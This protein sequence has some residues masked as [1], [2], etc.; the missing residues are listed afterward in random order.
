ML[1]W[2]PDHAF[3][4][5]KMPTGS[6]ILFETEVPEGY[7]RN[8]VFYT[9]YLEWHTEN[10]KVSEWCYA[11]VGNL[12]VI[13]PY[14]AEDYYTFLRNSNAAAKAD[15]LLG[16]FSGKPGTMIQDTLSG[17]QDMT[18]LT[19]AFGAN[20]IYNSFGGKLVYDSELAL[21]Q[22]LTKYLYTYGRTTQN[23]LMFAAKVAK[24]SKNVVS[25]EITPDWK[26]YTATS[27]IRTN[28]ALQL[29]SVIRGIASSVDTSG[30]S[31]VSSV[32]KDALNEA[33]NNLDTTNRIVEE[34]VAVQEQVKEAVTNA[35]TKVVTKTANVLANFGKW[36]IKMGNKP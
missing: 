25:C 19:I 14:F 31:V 24:E 26:Y 32:V 36:L 6:Y 10:P 12:G 18:A 4:T 35:A 21:A 3:F 27:S 5:K 13:L 30:S 17:S 8:P 2:L 7:L 1:Q 29:Q 15:E 33:A 34:T 11:T 28:I 20:L 9:I 22:D 16:K 23:L